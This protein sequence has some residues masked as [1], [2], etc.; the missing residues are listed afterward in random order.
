MW[1]GHNGNHVASLSN[2]WGRRVEYVGAN[3]GC[4]GDAVLKKVKLG[5]RSFANL[6]SGHSHK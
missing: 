3:S 2:T 1:H 6:Y 5:E 4:L